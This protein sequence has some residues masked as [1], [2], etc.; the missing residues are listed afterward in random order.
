[1]AAGVAHQP[2]E[3]Y[4]LHESNASPMEYAAQVQGAFHF[5]LLSEIGL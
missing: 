2:N 3:L 1:M 5:P 4:S